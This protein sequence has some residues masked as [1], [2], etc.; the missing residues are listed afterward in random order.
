[1][2]TLSLAQQ[3][4]PAWICAVVPKPYTLSYIL[5]F[6]DFGFKNM[7]CETV[8]WEQNEKSCEICLLNWNTFWFLH[9]SETKYLSR[10]GKQGIRGLHLGLCE[11]QTSVM[12]QVTNRG[13]VKIIGAIEN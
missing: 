11:T 1:M 5:Y 6:K 7:I 12:D 2:A 3:K 4:L 8:C 10:E 13:N 9:P